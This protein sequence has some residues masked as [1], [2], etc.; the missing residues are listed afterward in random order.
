MPQ[1]KQHSYATRGARPLRKGMS[2]TVGVIGLNDLVPLLESAGV[3]VVTG[4]TVKA[5]AG[6][7]KAR[8]EQIGTFPILV[9]DSDAKGLHNWAAAVAKIDN[10]PPVAVVGATRNH[11]TDEAIDHIT[12]PVTLAELGSRVGVNIESETT[13]PEAEAAPSASSAEAIPDF[14]DDDDEPEQTAAPAQPSAEVN[15]DST[16][17]ATPAPQQPQPSTPQGQTG[18]TSSSVNWDST[19]SAQTHQQAQPTPNPA[20]APEPAPAPAQPSPEPQ[21][22]EAAPVDPYRDGLYAAEVSAAAQ[23]MFNA[24]KRRSQAPVITV[25]SGK[26]GVGK[27]SSAIQIATTAAAAG[28]RTILVDGNRGQGD[29]SKYLALSR[30]MEYDT[31]TIADYLDHG[32]VKRLVLGARTLTRMRPREA[33]EIPEDLGVVLAPHHKDERLSEVDATVY[34][35]VINQLREFCDLLVIDTQIIEADDA[36]GM[37]TNMIVPLL[38]DGGFGLGIS[39]MSNAG[40][41]NLTERL[42]LLATAGVDRGRML[43]ALNMAEPDA[44]AGLNDFGKDKLDGK[45]G[46]FLGVIGEDH[47]IQQLMNHGELDLRNKEFD[48]I[49]NETLY[50]TTNAEVFD[51]PKP[52]QTPGHGK[53]NKK[54]PPPKKDRPERQ[55]KGREP[56]KDSEKKPGLFARLFGRSA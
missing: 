56:R 5:A 31:P 13:Y 9:E 8:N 44:I 1:Q 11:I 32:E 48:Y 34:M 51:K 50:R 42:N 10:A 12:T 27:S 29:I 2:A 15:W 4:E 38:A 54:S 49:V 22:A 6:A 47:R 53:K 3:E 33:D 55:K 21:R 43:I 45:L 35:R 30:Q 23:E 18:Q 46:V 41:R 36:S 28:K 20:P 37:V 52:K 7:I 14:D 16:G 24:P 39:D 40:V 17:S 25:F 19:G 26:G